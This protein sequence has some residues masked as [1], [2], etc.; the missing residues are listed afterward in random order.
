MRVVVQRVRYAQV[1]VNKK[2]VGA[3]DQGLL[4]FIGVEDADSE[5]DVH[6]LSKKLIGLRIFNDEEG[7]MNCSIQQINGKLLCVSQF[8]LHASTKKGN[9]PSFFRAAQPAQAEFLY[10]LLI[11][12][13]REAGLSV[14]TSIFG[15]DMQV[16]LLNDGP[17]TIWMDSQNK[18]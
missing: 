12:Q 6:W 13:L 15:A 18:E 16:E 9:R 8:T 4:L 5:E 10:G 14:E 3:I 7:K 17:V 11:R 1:S 2:V